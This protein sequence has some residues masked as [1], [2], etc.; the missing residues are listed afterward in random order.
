[1]N[2]LEHLHLTV[3]AKINPSFSHI[4]KE[5]AQAFID[6]LMEVTD[7]KPL[8][9]LN[10]SG[11][12]DL[13]F[14][15]ESFIQMITTSHTSLHYFSSTNEIYFDLYSC[16]FFD[17]GKVIGLLHRTFGVVEWHGALYNRA[18]NKPPKIEIIGSHKESFILD[19]RI[20]K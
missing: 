15:G 6:E 20:I 1:M 2:E 19:Q 11:A 9:P 17:I 10:W 8:G 5:K 18:H 3:N 4:P 14:P 16:K 12:V 7:M 13:D